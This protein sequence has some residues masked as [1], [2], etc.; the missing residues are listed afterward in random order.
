LDALARKVAALYSPFGRWRRLYAEFRVG[1]ARFDLVEHHLPAR[2][3]VL[4]LG[5]GYGIA[6]NYL[7]LA[8]P[9]RTVI[10]IDWDKERIAVA[11]QTIA[12]R[13]NPQFL[14]GDVIS[15]DLP[16]ADI[17]FMNDFLHHLLPADQLAVLK[18]VS[19][20]LEKGATLL[21][22]EVNT[23]PRWKFWC[24]WVS[25]MLLYK[26]QG[27]HFRGPDDW[28]QLLSGAGFSSVE[29]IRGDQGSPFARVSYIARK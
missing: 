5:C 25:D 7:A 28:V 2:G 10:G 8:S 3:L 26:F 11:R 18:H 4:D 9:G 16:R 23:V 20:V 29:V 15:L 19:E 22:H 13:S 6:S 12:G 17:V 14:E 24:S 21:I 1:L 27:G